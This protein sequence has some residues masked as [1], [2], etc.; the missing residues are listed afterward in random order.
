MMPLL[1]VSSLGGSEAPDR[2]EAMLLGAL[3]AALTLA[4]G[5]YWVV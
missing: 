2:K 5:S 3:L 4:I 1:L